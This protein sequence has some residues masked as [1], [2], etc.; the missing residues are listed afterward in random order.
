MLGRDVGCQSMVSKEATFSGMA[1]NTYRSEDASQRSKAGGERKEGGG[2]LHGDEIW[3]EGNVSG[4]RMKKRASMKVKRLSSAAVQSTSWGI[5]YTFEGFLRMESNATF[6]LEESIKLPV[7]QLVH[8]FLGKFIP[9]CHQGS[10]ISLDRPGS[11]EP[12]C[13]ILR[14][15]SQRRDDQRST[16]NGRRHR[17]AEFHTI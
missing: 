6:A 17:K 16:T 13:Q 5:L 7:N 1:V 14:S 4:Q 15:L 12:H 8:C 9:K 11:K 3:S 10:D 2:G